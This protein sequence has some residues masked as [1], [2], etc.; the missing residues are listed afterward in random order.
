M[1]RR[2]TGELGFAVKV[3]LVEPRTFERATEGKTRRVID[4]RK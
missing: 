4:K 2:I 1:A 3:M